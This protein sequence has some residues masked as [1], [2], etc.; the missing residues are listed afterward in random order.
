MELINQAHKRGIRIILD[1]V[2]NH[3]GGGFR[4]FQDVVEHGSSPPF[5]TGS[6]SGSS[7]SLRPINFDAFGTTSL[8][9]QPLGCEGYPCERLEAD[10]H[11]Q[12][13]HGKTPSEGISAG[14][15]AKWDL[16]GH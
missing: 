16:Y 8:C 3:C 1:G 9:A 2:F 12:A 5:K 13:E 10:V 15:V 11:A 7:P 6:T 4:Q 14:A